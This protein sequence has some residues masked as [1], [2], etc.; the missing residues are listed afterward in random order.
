[1]KKPLVWQ[2]KIKGEKKGGEKLMGVGARKTPQKKRGTKMGPGGVFTATASLSTKVIKKQRKRRGH[3][4]SEE[5]SRR[6]TVESME[7]ENNDSDRANST[8]TP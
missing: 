8:N 2:R 4:K 3:E 7:N 5:R 6:E 1:M